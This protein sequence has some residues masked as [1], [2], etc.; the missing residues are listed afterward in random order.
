MPGPSFRVFQARFTF[1]A[2]CLAEMLSI[3]LAGLIDWIL[4]LDFRIGC[5]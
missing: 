5:F 1:F 4:M 3:A 2:L